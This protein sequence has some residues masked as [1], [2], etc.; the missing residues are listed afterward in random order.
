[1]TQAASNSPDTVALFDARPFFE[2]ALAY[3]VAHGI[4]T[5]DK[6]TAI[7]NDGP[8]GMVQIA[9]YFGTEFL[10]PELERARE[11]MVN[12]ISLYL[13]YTSQGDLHTAAQALRDHS[14]LSRSKGGSDMLKALLVMPDH[15][16]FGMSD[17]SA[18]TTFS[19]DQIPLL[20]RWALRPLRD[21]QQELAA[22]TG[23]QQQRDAAIWFARKLGLPRDDLVDAQTDAEAVIRTGLLMAAAGVARMPNWA[24]F[25]RAVLLL[26][27][28]H[29]ASPGALQIVVP[30]DLPAPYQAIVQAVRASVLRDDLPK[31]LDASITPRK[32]LLQSLGFMGKYFWRDEGIEDVS[33]FDNAVSAQW[34]KLTQQHTDDSSLLTLFLCITAD[35]PRKTTLTETS[36]ASLVR[37]LRKNGLD[38]TLA[39]AFI[40]EHAPHEHHNDYQRLWTAFIADAERDLMDERDTRL[41]EA[42]GC[43]QLHC[44]I[45]QAVK[46]QATRA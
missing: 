43:L 9:R 2:K 6:V 10:R 12:L 33:D 8:K 14:L 21:Y 31:L 38:T 18:D 26:R 28:R 23:M 35:V 11:R 27:K 3:G 17:S 13:E 15:S 39:S 30:A 24:Q 40:R 4:I 29:A 19:D 7:L 46:K 5:P 37:K 32:L 20:A 41:V 36:A 22:R 16:H 44:N 34:A 45:V 1:M 25:E 42:M